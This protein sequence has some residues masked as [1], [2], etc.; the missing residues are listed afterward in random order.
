LKLAVGAADVQMLIAASLGLAGL[1]ALARR[2]RSGAA[3]AGPGR[4]RA[5]LALLALVALL[6]V[7]NYF[8]LGRHPTQFVKAW[9]AQHTWFGSKYAA[10]L[11]YFRLYE[12][13]LWFDARE[14]HLYR[15]VRRISDLRTP[16]ARVAAA[17]A[18]QRTDC[19]SRFTPARRDEFARDLTFF[20]SLRERPLPAAW[21]VDNGYNQSPFFT[22]LTSPL[23]QRAPPGYGLLVG[24]ALVDV[25]LLL[26]PFALVWRAFGARTALFAAIFLFDFFPQ[27]FAVMGGSILRF[28]WLA[29]LLG[30]ACA[31]ERA[32]PLAAGVALGFATLL[33]VFPV[34]YAAGLALAVGW[35]AL[36]TRRLPPWALRFFGAYA[37][38][39]AAGAAA[40]LLVVSTEAWREFAAKMG[41]HA[42]ILSQFRA[43]LRLVLVLDWPPP[44]G[45]WLP[46]AAKAAELREL[47]LLYV[48]CGAALLAAVAALAPK[49]RPPELAAL[50]TS[51]ALYVI[52]PVHYYLAALVLLFFVVREDDR[53][54]RAAP[55]G[56]SLLFLVSA[57]AFWIHRTSGS[58]AL[59]NDYW[60]SVALL[61]VL[62]VWIA[63]LHLERPALGLAEFEGGPPAVRR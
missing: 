41:A 57:G 30:A 22:A 58:L 1:A 49:L 8:V 32:R 33:Q 54:E 55:L 20:Q 26:L 62:A 5:A 6:S 60:L 50:F 47:R 25:A 36:R 16:Q 13:V 2:G 14:A 12:C 42:E 28:A 9:D 31:L 39:L 52:T 29:L 27:Q 44:P 10:E 11:G 45:G 21:F 15:D 51:A 53:R 43:G 19:E 35:R 3:P 18:L 24:L 61:V 37:A 34:L 46:F 23:L 7:S 17:E 59:V 4:E 63:A 38:A 48:A 40:S 56:R